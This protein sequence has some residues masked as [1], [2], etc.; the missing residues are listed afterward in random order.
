MNLL[1]SCR[2]LSLIF[3]F[4]VVAISSLL[5]LL[6]PSQYLLSQVSIDLLISFAA[7][8][9]AVVI[10][11]YDPCQIGLEKGSPLRKTVSAESFILSQASS[12]V[13][14]ASYATTNSQLS[15]SI[16]PTLQKTETA[17]LLMQDKATSTQYSTQR[18]SSNEPDGETVDSPNSDDGLLP[19]LQSYQRVLKALYSTVIVSLTFAALTRF[20]WRSMQDP[21]GWFV[22]SLCMTCIFINFCGALYISRAP[23]THK[24][25]VYSA[26][27]VP[28]LQ[29]LAVMGLCLMLFSVDAEAWIRWT[30][31]TSLGTNRTPYQ[32]SKCHLTNTQFF[33]CRCNILFVLQSNAK[34][35]M[36]FK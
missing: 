1:F 5:A 19:D 26:G 35:G 22:L 34:C 24:E 30:I 6:V 2:V 21:Y 8:C 13:S 20:G 12:C 16:N 25:Q 36:F 31:W 28:F 29:I 17:I 3:R 18:F 32:K 11:R 4:F 9:L 7:T 23:I 15:Q 10:V 14:Q 27:G 33:S